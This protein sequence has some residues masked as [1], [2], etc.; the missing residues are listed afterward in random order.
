[1]TD[2]NV[3]STD[4]LRAVHALLTFSRDDFTALGASP[5][6][7]LLLSG[8]PGVGKTHAVTSIAAHYNIPIHFV[9]PGANAYGRLSKAFA[10]AYDEVNRSAD[11]QTAQQRHSRSSIVFIDELDAVCPAPAEH[12]SSTTSPAASLL[13]SCLDSA[14]VIHDDVTSIDLFV[15]AATNRPS[16]VHPVLLRTGRFHRHVTLRAPTVSE[17]LDLLR[18]LLPTVDVDTLQKVSDH[19]PGFVAADLS[20][21]CRDA[22]SSCNEQCDRQDSGNVGE[23]KGQNNGVGTPCS[24]HLLDAVRNV[25]PSALRTSLAPRLAHTPWSAVAG[26]PEVKRRLQMA[27]EWPLLHACT[28]QKLGLTTPRG[29]LLHGPPGCSKTTLVRAAATAARAPFLRLTAADVYS[30]FV[31]DSER[32]LRDAFAAA[33]AAAPCIL[34]LDEIDSVAGKRQLGVSDGS[35]GVQHRV[36]STL[37]TEMDGVSSANGVLVIAATNRIDMLDDALLRPGRF[38][39]VLYVGLPDA[40]TRADILGMYS[41]SMPLADDVDTAILVEKSEGWSGADLKALCAEA[42]LIAMR[43]A[44]DPAKEVANIRVYMC[45]FLLALQQHAQNLRDSAD[46]PPTSDDF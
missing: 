15:I 38:D 14:H 6:R 32:I 27:V 25:I 16:G 12:A 1:M 35:G 7:H 41:G 13:A 43:Q 24:Q 22:R 2:D 46:E 29:I 30:S 21:L 8:P 34:F 33:R 40:H 3:Q 23:S 37:L 9:L 4:A 5:P 19:T 28:F 42:A 20:A 45:H 36:L 31:G 44:C 39:D 17:R 11:R 18:I 26:V 10:A